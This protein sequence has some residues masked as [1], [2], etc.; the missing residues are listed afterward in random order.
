MWRFR[1][2][3]IAKQELQEA[4]TCAR[5]NKEKTYI[6]ICAFYFVDNLA[7]IPLRFI[8]VQE[9]R[10]RFGLE[11]DDVTISIT[12]FFNNRGRIT[13]FITISDKRQKC[14]VFFGIQ[15]PKEVAIAKG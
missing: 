7:T 1:K 11:N 2:A 5:E 6:E 10:H 15:L 12:R 8:Q 4:V 9:I 14:A 13:R 3:N